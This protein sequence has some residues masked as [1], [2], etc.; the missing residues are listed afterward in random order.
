MGRVESGRVR[1]GSHY[2]IIFL[3]RSEPD[4]IKFGSKNLDPYPTRRDTGQFDPTRRDTGQFDP[5]RRVTG[6]SDP[7]RVK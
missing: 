1:I 7:T 6:R 4:P 3:I 5:T 2:F